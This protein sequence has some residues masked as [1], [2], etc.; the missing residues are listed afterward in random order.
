MGV[1][2]ILLGQ[3]PNVKQVLNGALTTSITEANT[4]EDLDNVIQSLMLADGK[5]ENRDV[6]IPLLQ[7]N[8][9]EGEKSQ[10][11]KRK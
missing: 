1:Q 6:V 8:I 4:E 3:H 11:V 7:R 10:T 2:L 9:E 5:N